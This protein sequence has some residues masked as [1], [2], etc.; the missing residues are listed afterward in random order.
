MS[1]ALRMVRPP[2]ALPGPP[3]QRCFGFLRLAIVVHPYTPRVAKPATSLAGRGL[4][5][6][7]SIAIAVQL[8]LAPRVRC[9]PKPPR[10]AAKLE[11]FAPRKTIVGKKPRSLGPQ[12]MTAVER[13]QMKADVAEL[14]RAR[15]YAKRPKT[16]GEC[17]PG[18]CPWMT[19]RHH[20]KYDID[21]ATGIIKDMWPGRDFDEMPE[22]CSLRVAARIG[23]RA[24]EPLSLGKV[25]AFLNLTMQR[26]A[27]IEAEA[28]AKVRRALEAGRQNRTP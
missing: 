12:H 8:P 10:R 23:A 25:G 9:P 18:P 21:D 19:C 1:L 20:L 17:Q 22:T 3:G 4:L 7:N 16:F 27:Q 26:V 13:A 6:G 15:V 24:G 11:V 28:Q 14:R 5:P 2:A